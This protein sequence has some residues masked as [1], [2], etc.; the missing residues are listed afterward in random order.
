[1]FERISEAPVAMFHILFESDQVPAQ[2][3]ETIAA[4]LLAAGYVTLRQTP[5]SGAARGA[6]CMMGACFDC[7]VQVDGETVQA[8]MTL[9]QPG[10]EIKRVPLADTFAG[11]GR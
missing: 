10:M 3:G 7:L 5:V 2:Q 11:A 4:A 1:M 9:V 8:C 6:F